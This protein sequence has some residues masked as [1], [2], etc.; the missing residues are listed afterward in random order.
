MK[1]A[2]RATMPNG[3]TLIEMVVA[4]AIVGILIA[5]VAPSMRGAIARQRVQ[6]VNA[7]LVTDLQMA[8]SVVARHNGDSVRVSFG[9]NGQMTCY[10]L[11]TVPVGVTASCDCTL[12][13]PNVCTPASVQA[14][15]TVQVARGDGVAIATNPA[16][17]VTFAPP[18]GLATPASFAVDVQSAVSGQL[19]TIVNSVGRPAVCSPNGS[20]AGVPTPC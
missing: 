9:S 14:I 10:T 12:T 2:L 3:V 1:P 15:K 13:P 8:R 4:I 16:S 18:Q 19:R 7:E 5:V 17:A 20:I 11:H 6:G